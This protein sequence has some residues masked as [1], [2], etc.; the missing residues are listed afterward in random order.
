[1]S[2]VSEIKN[3]DGHFTSTLFI[4]FLSIVAPG[5]LTIYLY[6]PELFIKLDS[7]KFVLFAISLSLPVFVLNGVIV[8]ICEDYEDEL[9]FQLT[10][11]SA[12]IM[13]SVIMFSSLA[14]SYVFVLNFYNFLKIVFAFEVLFFIVSLF[15]YRK[16]V[17][18][19]NLKH[20]SK[21][22]VE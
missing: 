20:E 14:I 12:G 5:V 17:Y 15:I 16:N 21:V 13:S 7:L 19:N 4:L 1:V 18:K 11:I 3:I 22:A 10:G 2:L 8:R 9:D 6:L